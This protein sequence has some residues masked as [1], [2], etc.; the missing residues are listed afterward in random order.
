MLAWRYEV[1]LSVATKYFT[2][3]LC[4][5]VKC[6]CHSKINFIPSHHHVISSIYLSEKIVS[7][8]NVTILEHGTKGMYVVYKPKVCYE[9]LIQ[10]LTTWFNSFSASGDKSWHLA[11]APIAIFD[12][13]EA[14]FLPLN[15]I[16]IRN[17]QILWKFCWIKLKINM[18]MG[19]TFQII[20]GA[21]RV[22]VVLPQGK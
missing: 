4:T 20:S 2:C 3:T 13:T 5:L 15:F 10:L 16:H 18:A 1:Y 12:N 22:H 14:T 6:F 21:E 19:D 11:G 7:K 17:S 8:E 9:F